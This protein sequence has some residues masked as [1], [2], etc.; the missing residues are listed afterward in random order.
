MTITV[1]LTLALTYNWPINQLNVRNA[2]LNGTLEEDIFMQQPPGFEQ[3]DNMFVC[4]LNKAIYGLKL[5]PRAWFERFTST[6]NKLGFNASQCDSSLFI[7]STRFHTTYILVY[8]DDILVE[9]S[10]REAISR[11]STALNREFS[12]R[13]M[14]QV[15]FFLGIEVNRTK[16]GGLHL[17]QSKYIKDIMSKANMQSARGVV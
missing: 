15:S 13:D 10:S 12:L 7:N 1:V 8:V 4:K 14:G 5:A 3:A 16:E 6:L 2:F 9:G 11:V 17:S